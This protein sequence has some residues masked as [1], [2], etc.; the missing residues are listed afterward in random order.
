MDTTTQPVTSP[1][2]KKVINSCVGGAGIPYWCS[3]PGFVE[4]PR[5][6]AVPA[7]DV[8]TYET[9][10]QQGRVDIHVSNI[11]SLFVDWPMNGSDVITHIVTKSGAF[12]KTKSV[13]T[14]GSAFTRTLLIVR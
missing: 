2:T 14:G 1:A 9:G 7:Y 4:S 13:V 8:A 5:I 10:R 6:V 12:D 3:K 11:V